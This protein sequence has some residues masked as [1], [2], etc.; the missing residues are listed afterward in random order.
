[1]L[2]MV[3]MEDLHR[4]CRTLRKPTGKGHRRSTELG[5]G[6]TAHGTRL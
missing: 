4:T 6:Q 1:L 5:R 3:A 2:A